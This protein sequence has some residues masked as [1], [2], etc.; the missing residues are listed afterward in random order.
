MKI[1]KMLSNNKNRFYNI[2][3]CNYITIHQT[4]NTGKGSNARNH[5]K[6]MNNGS[7]ATWHYTVDD[8]EVIQHFD[9]TV[10]CW[11]CGD[12]R[13][14]GNTESIG[15]ELCI[16]SDGNYNQTISNAVELV[17]HLMQIHNIPIER[18]VQHNK[19]SGK[20]CP[21]QI[22]G[23][24]NGISWDMFIQFIKGTKSYTP[25]EVYSKKTTTYDVDKIARD[26]IAGKYGNGEERRKKLGSKYN[27]VQ[28][29][30]NELLKK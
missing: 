26:V 11:H 28:K 8:K 12:G 10:Q 3:P 22:R 4:G 18:V 9:D 30:V 20:N 21:A 29:R 23:R 6:Y 24:F 17:K 5:A 19:W 7:P 2:N 13:G 27:V 14:K 16:N 1:I 25:I 15:I